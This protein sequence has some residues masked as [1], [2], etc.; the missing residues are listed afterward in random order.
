LL[1]RL[2]LPEREKQQHRGE[3]LVTAWTNY[4][5]KL[6][7]SSATAAP[8][9]ATVCGPFENRFLKSPGHLI[10]ISV[11]STQSLILNLPDL[12]AQPLMPSGLYESFSPEI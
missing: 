2:A 4:G 12:A 11:R 8:A 6:A 10:K 7:N 9:L 1:Q 3:V 5:I